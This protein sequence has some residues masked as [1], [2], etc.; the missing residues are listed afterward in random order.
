[1]KNLFFLSLGLFLF[2]TACDPNET[3]P[4][5]PPPPP[6]PTVRLI[7]PSNADSLSAALIM[8][9]GTKRI[10]GQIMSKGNGDA[11]TLTIDNPIV[12]SSNGSTPVI[13]LSYSGMSENLGGCFVYVQGSSTYFKV[14]YESTYNS[15][16]H[17]S[18]PIG[19]PSNVDQGEFCITCRVYDASG[20]VSN[21]RDA[22]FTV[23]QLGT[24]SLQISLTWDNDS[25]QDLIVYSPNGDTVHRP[26]PVSPDGGVLDREDGDGYGPENIYWENE[27]PDGVYTISVADH[28]GNDETS[29][30]IVTVNSQG[31]FRKFTG[32]TLHGNKVDVV[33]FS[34]IGKAISF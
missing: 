34:K 3:D 5:L 11:P 12:L 14:P 16:G 10:V 21:E 28:S 27:A 6:Q 31:I 8:P 4:I 24:G 30:F 13:N 33:T 20:N 18:L 9:N 32:S 19:I 7:S 26:R 1:M 29:N 15:P 22:C 25:D 2:I 23:L 17:I